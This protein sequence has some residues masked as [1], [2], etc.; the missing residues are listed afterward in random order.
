MMIQLA[1]ARTSVTIIA[2]ASDDHA[3]TRLWDT[4]RG[5]DVEGCTPDRFH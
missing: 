2:T 1:Q 3:P 4:D 5:H